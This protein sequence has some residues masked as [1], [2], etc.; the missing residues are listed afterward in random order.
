MLISIDIVLREK[1]CLF[2]DN[3]KHKKEKDDA[4]RTVN[5]CS[6]YRN[7]YNTTNELVRTQAID[8]TKDEP[9]DLEP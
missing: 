2:V 6:A 7:F 3:N 9:K 5:I 8:F 1:R 4:I